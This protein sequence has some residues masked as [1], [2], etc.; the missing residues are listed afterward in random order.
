M[1]YKIGSKG[2]EVKEIQR[3]LHLK[4]DGYFGLITEEAVMAF[5]KSNNLT[6]DGI[7]G[8]ATLSKLK[9]TSTLKKSSR[10]I[11][12]III[13]CSATV[14]GK[15]YTTEDIKTWHLKAGYADIGYHYVIYRDGSIH[16]GRDVNKIGAHCAGHNTYSIGICYIGG[17]D[18]NN[19]PKDTRTDAQK[20]ALLKLLKQLKNIYPNVII[21]GHNEYSTKACPS[22]DVQKEYK[23]KI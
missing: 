17:V 10:V 9:S 8:P 22:F 3:L 1:I 13:H 18:K 15:D 19:I 6:V 16:N 4:D 12:E 11:K 2:E 7:V 5:Q 21:H 20:E 14:E 23:G